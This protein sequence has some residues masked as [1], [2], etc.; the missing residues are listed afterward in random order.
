MK[1]SFSPSLLSIVTPICLLFQTLIGLTTTAQN[2][3]IPDQNFKNSLLGNP[4]INTVADWEIS[5][6]E[7]AAVSGELNV[8]G[9]DI[10]DLTG[11]EAFTALTSL[12]C[13]HNQLTTLDVSANTA[14]TVLLCHSNNLTALDISANMDL[15][16]MSCADN[17]LTT[18]DISTN[19]TLTQLNCAGNLITE[20]NLSA[21]MNLNYLY[22]TFG[23]LTTLNLANGNNTNMDV[24]VLNNPDLLCIQVDDVNEL[25]LLNWDKDPTASYSEE[26]CTTSIST[27]EN[28]TVL[29]ICPNPVSNYL[30][31]ES[32]D[33]QVKTIT[34]YNTKGQLVSSFS[35]NSSRIDVS[36]LPAGFYLLEAATTKGNFS[37]SFIKQ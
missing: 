9:Q 8:A 24:N 22:C 14:L 5:F 32:M 6:A 19:L 30:S 16:N 25:N 11:I 31:L 23:Q 4:L 1:S 20:L 21:N 29:N 34:I 35:S 33:A 10:S 36:S 2:V 13:N 12:H 18:L 37:N 26:D 27:P 3:N 15:I 7:A 28:E 17:L